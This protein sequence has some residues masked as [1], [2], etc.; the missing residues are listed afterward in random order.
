[1][2]S[3]SKK[4]ATQ[5]VFTSPLDFQVR[6]R[7][8]AILTTSAFAVSEPCRWVS[9]MLQKLPMVNPRHAAWCP[10][11][12]FS[13]DRFPSKLRE[14]KATPATVAGCRMNSRVFQRYP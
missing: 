14:M 4:S 11:H 10:T 1:L 7:T 12:Y 9:S 13:D 5:A 3:W 8:V 6:L 2:P